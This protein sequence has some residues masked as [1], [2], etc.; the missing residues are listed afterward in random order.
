MSNVL[1]AG[2][3]VGE[4]I[5]PATWPAPA[6]IGLNALA[7]ALL[8]SQYFGSGLADR[9]L[10]LRHS[11]EALATAVTD[12]RGIAED[13]TY[14][15][16][17]YTYF[18][19]AGPP[20]TN[21]Q[22]RESL[23][24]PVLRPH[25]RLVYS[26][27]NDIGLPTFFRASF[28]VFGVSLRAPH[29]L[30]FALLG[31]S[32]LF[33]VVAHR[34]DPTSLCLA[35]FVV[36]AIYA[37]TYVLAL[38][39]QLW[40]A[41]DVRF[42]SALAILPCLALA[43]AVGARRWSWSE[44]LL[45]IPQAALIA[46]VY[47]VR[48]SAAWTIVCLIVV[49]AWTIVACWKLGWVPRAAATVPL[50]V[51]GVLLLAFTMHQRQRLSEQ[52]RR[53]IRPGHVFWHSLHTGFAVNPSLA[54]QYALE[55]ADLPSYRA[56]MRYVAAHD[57]H[58]MQAVFGTDGSVFDFTR[59]NWIEYERAAR[60]VV[61]Q[62]VRDEPRAAVKTFAYDK[63]LMLIKTLGWATGVSPVPIRTIA[64]EPEWLSP[65]SQRRAN[66][67]Y[68]RWF[69]PAAACLFLLGAVCA[70]WSRRTSSAPL[71]LGPPQLV[72]PAMFLA[73]ALP[74]LFVWPAFHWIA[75]TM[76][77]TGLLVYT[78][79][80]WCVGFIVDGALRLHPRAAARSRDDRFRVTPDGRTTD[81]KNAR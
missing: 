76:I 44:Q 56:V 48:I 12:M 4:R 42:L 73:S 79:L 26:K 32:L 13:S 14:A 7:F 20:L 10:A 58:R 22:L 25:E 9:P 2:R 40:T 59:V 55:F 63:P 37:M 23:T 64:M 17:L 21:E 39:T 27:V 57:P 43:L 51:T 75:D 49:A 60:A 50:L 28:R 1:E 62:M 68:L 80:A 29:Y 30:F 18:W 3:S 15:I 53:E 5:G 54:R 6:L 61:M 47:Q 78:V 31:A 35:L 41:I 34:R 74:G 77:T 46:A 16:E 36:L 11:S 65:P 19:A 8:L 71:S 33:F 69:R 24:L 67:E 52:Y 70:G 38:S 45:G 81:L 72:V 66:D